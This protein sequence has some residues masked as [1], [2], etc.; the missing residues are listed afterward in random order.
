MSRFSALDPYEFQGLVADLLGAEIGARYECFAPGRD[1]GIDLRLRDAAGK[2]EIVQIKHFER[3]PFSTLRSA[4]REERQKVDALDPRPDCYR[5]VTSQDLSVDQKAKL[6]RDL[7]PYVDDEAQILG[8]SDLLRLLAKHAT[9]EQGHPKLWLSSGAHLSAIV[10]AD[11]RERS[12][13]L[14]ADIDGALATYVQHQGFPAARERLHAGRVLVITGDPGVGKTT[15][16][17][18]LLAD[19][20]DDGFDEP[21]AVS[22]HTDEASGIFDPTRKQ[23]ILYDDFLGR[24]A[25]QRLDKN[26]DRELM[27][28]MRRVVHAPHTLLLLTTRA[29]I[30]RHATQLHEELRHGGIEQYTFHLQPSHYGLVERA[31]LFVNHARH[32][33]SLPAAAGRALM[34]DDAYLR[35]V[36]HPNYNPR[37]IAYVTGAA[38]PALRLERPEGYVDFAVRTLDDPAARWRQTFRYELADAERALLL[39]LVS[40]GDELQVSN[41]RELYDSLAPH[42]GASPGREAFDDALGSLEGSLV[43]IRHDE[44]SLLFAAPGDPSVQDYL[45]EHVRGHPG[46]GAALL[47]GALA[48]EQVDWVVG[49]CKGEYLEDTLAAVADATQRTY[50]APWLSWTGRD[51]DDRLPFSALRDQRQLAQRLC[52]IQGFLLE[53]PELEPMLRD[54]WTQRLGELLLSAS[55]PEYDNLQRYG[56]LALARAAKDYVAAIPN[57]RKAL[58]DLIAYDLSW[59]GAWRVLYE[60]HDAW[61]QLYAAR[62]WGQLRKRYEQWAIGELKTMMELNYVEEV[63][64]IAA[65]AVRM[66]VSLSDDIVERGRAFAEYLTGTPKERE[67]KLSGEPQARPA[68]RHE[69]DDARALF[70]RFAEE[71]HGP[72]PDIPAAASPARSRGTDAPRPPRAGHRPTR[73]DDPHK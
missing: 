21:V 61:P 9:V 30:L 3:S 2:L 17:H 68:T 13:A 6:A 55:G 64:E 35:V 57:G 29:Y 58:A 33:G 28:L 5:F 36:E 14:L 72:Q 69:L 25:L 42:L 44:T 73:A 18:M 62:R 56:L 26:Q 48:L 39:A 22:R 53:H 50:E 12:R 65:L 41:L 40:A 37:G 71:T 23:I 49:R 16:A 19:A 54:W 24:E 11:V 67:Y 70:A 1:H 4:A 63:D 52:A 27:S 7:E 51:I 60:A 46:H 31:R 59:T 47:A 43:R 34:T 20:I 38:G 45:V 15:L 10:H 8:Y 32:A 66:Q